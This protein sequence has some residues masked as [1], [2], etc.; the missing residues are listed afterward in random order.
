MKRIA[1]ISIVAA[2]A[3]TAWA[4]FG[5]EPTPKKLLFLG[6]SITWHP[7]AADIGW[8]GNWGMAASC[9]END[10]V[11]RVAAGYAAAYGVAPTL[12]VRSIVAGFEGNGAYANWTAANDSDYQQDLAF[13]PDVVVIAIGENLGSYDA[14]VF[15]EKFLAYC[16]GFAS[17]SPKPTM[18]IRAPFWDNSAV[19]AIEQA[20][21]EEV[22]AKFIHV[23]DIGADVSNQA[24]GLFSHS[25]V[26]SH[27]GDKGMKAIAE[28]ML[29]ALGVPRV[30]C[31]EAPAGT[32]YVL[33]GN[34]TFV[35]PED[36]VLVRALVVG[37][38]GSGGWML[39]GGGGGGQV[40][41]VDFGD[42]GLEIPKGTVFTFT[43]GDGGGNRTNVTAIATTGTTTA[44]FDDEVLQGMN[45][46][47]TTLQFLDRSYVSVGG[48]GG[49]GWELGNGLDGACGGGGTSAGSA[50]KG[51]SGGD[52]GKNP[53]P[54]LLR[55]SGGGGGVDETGDGSKGE[56][57]TAITSGNG[58]VGIALPDFGAQMAYGAGGGG[59]GYSGITAGKGG[60][61]S[62]GNGSASSV[63][64]AGMAGSGSGGGGGGFTPQ[65]VYAGG[66]GGSGTIILAFRND[67]SA[68]LAITRGLVNVTQ[69]EHGTCYAFCSSGT[70]TPNEDLILFHALV[71]GGGG[72]GGWMLGGGGGGGG[73]VS[74]GYVADGKKTVLKKG[75]TYSITVGAGGGNRVAGDLSSSGT[76]RGYTECVDGLPGEPS[77]L[78]IGGQVYTA[79]GGGYGASWFLWD[80][81][82]KKGV[83]AKYVPGGVGA[84]GGGSSDKSGAGGMG[85]MGGNGGASVNTAAGG[86]GGMCGAGADGCEIATDNL[87]SGDGGAG[88][89]SA[90]T[91]TTVI[92]GAGGGGGG[93]V[94]SGNDGRNVPAGKAGGASAGAGGHGTVGGNALPNT[95]SGG[96]GGGWTGWSIMYRGGNGGSGTV[97]LS[98]MTVADFER[99]VGSMGFVVDGEHTVSKR[100]KDYVVTLKSSGS[101]KAFSKLKILRALVVGGGG[102][103]G[104]MVGGGGGG[105]EVVEYRPE[106]GSELC[107]D[108]GTICPVAI[109]QGGGNRNSV[110]LLSGD[111]RF[112]SRID[113]MPGGASSI[114]LGSA[115]NLVAAGGGYGAGWL[116]WHDDTGKATDEPVPGGDGACGGG[117]C[118]GNASGGVGSAG[119]N[120][121]AN[122]GA[123]GGGGGMG[124]NGTDGFF[125]VYAQR[126]PGQSGAGGAG[127][128]NDIT[129]ADCV[130]GAGGGAGGLS[131]TVNILAGAAGAETA[132][133][134]GFGSAVGGNAVDGFGGGGGGGGCDNWS[135]AYAGGNG[136][137]GAVILVVRPVKTGL[138][139]I[140]R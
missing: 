44:D 67:T 32:V 102:S 119:G 84:C 137:D 5:E 80:E 37:G 111:A 50:G 112:K 18:L 72:S 129:G 101:L 62:A 98:V 83:D 120:G 118:G 85:T 130:Y 20:V 15:R 14:T 138:A 100:S 7:P 25:G 10:Y 116:L 48:G 88:F 86:G 71:V 27:P 28:C 135:G 40:Q 106:K 73:V 125:Y 29:A 6:N 39:G 99:D 57:G 21:A 1:L 8:S 24:Q 2:S 139:V 41:D 107:L 66:A 95:G 46:E 65:N 74:L 61:A 70:F 31:R 36:G 26:A 79:S 105:G 76:S 35:M 33:S 117:S 78:T 124:G 52:G 69:P 133:A 104:W 45:G 92:Y 19:A 43:V 82:A 12:R 103:G 9:E 108:K 75:T 64:G 110:T 121:G 58:G 97:I 4:S 140:L 59:G 13:Q 128:T 132:G 87:I 136:G 93:Q 81:G 90:I 38:G 109:G 123:G 23:G 131:Y 114:R 54:D 127:V 55:G 96:G 47:P 68:P 53:E 134:G 56:D 122:N 30:E 34:G 77:S 89:A 63:G 17:L 11:H 22:G 126:I 3:I 91:G 16:Q 42:A 51:T 60:S 113:G 49:G 115:T 94:K